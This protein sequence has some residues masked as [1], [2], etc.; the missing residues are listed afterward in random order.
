MMYEEMEVQHHAIYTL[1]LDGGDWSASYPRQQFN[2]R[3][4]PWYTMGRLRGPRS[5]PG[6][7]ADKKNLYQ[8]WELNSDSSII[9][10]VAHTLHWSSHMAPI[11]EKLLLCSD[12]WYLISLTQHKA[13]VNTVQPLLGFIFSKKVLLHS[14]MQCLTV[15][16]ITSVSLLWINL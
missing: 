2:C 13:V 6:W 3:K 4:R 8:Y 15:I 1:S 5:W 16:L 10:S 11:T 12:N 7:C 14:A 9:W